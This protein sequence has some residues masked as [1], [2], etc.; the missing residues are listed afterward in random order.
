[1]GYRLGKIGDARIA[2]GYDLR[3]KQDPSRRRW[4]P[5]TPGLTLRPLEWLEVSADGEYDLWFRT[6]R[7]ASG[8]LAFGS[9]GIGPYLKVAPRYTNNRL[10]LS[11]AASTAQDYRLARHL[12]GASY[13][14]AS[15][16]SKILLVDAEATTPILPHLRGSAIAQW[17]GATRKVHV[18]AATLTRD[19]HC[20]ELTGTFQRFAD[21][22]WRAN[23]ALGLVAFPAERLPLLGL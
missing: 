3:N 8:W 17:D 6:F 13:Q 2:T 15:A 14:D 5:V 20:W 4:T 7:G 16:Y 18:F 22:E 23:F 9:N 1:M 19:L 21:G 11:N 10:A 12:Y